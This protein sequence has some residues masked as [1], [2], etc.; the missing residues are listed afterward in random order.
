MHKN[1]FF[2][3]VIFFSGTFSGQL[4]SSDVQ[5]WK[6][7]DLTIREASLVSDEGLL[8]FNVG[9]KDKIA[10]KYI[11]HS[12]TKSHSLSIVHTSKEDEKIWEN[13]NR[14]SLFNNFFGK[15]QK[16]DKQ[17]KGLK[18]LNKLMGNSDGGVKI[19]K[20]PSI[21]SYVANA[22]KPNLKSDSSKINFEDKNLYELIF[23]S[24]KIK[25]I[26][27]DKI[28]SYLSIK[29]GI[30]LEKGKYIS[31]D[32]TLI[33]D[34]SKHKNFQ[35]RPTGL[36]RD[37]G[38]EL[39]QKQS[40]NAENQF[41][42][43]GKSDI[44]KMNV[45]NTSV[46]DDRNFVMWSDDNKDFTFRND[47][48][49]RILERNWEI[50]FVGTTIPKTD[51]KVRIEKKIINP[52]SLPQVYWMFLKTKDGETV[53][54]QGIENDSYIDFNKVNFQ[55]DKELLSQ[56]TFGVS[57]LKDIRSTS[58]NNTASSGITD[59]ELSLN[60]NDIVLYPNPVTSG[61]NF[62]IKFPEMENLSVSIYDGG[63]RLVKL[64][65][66]HHYSKSYSSSLTIQS[67]YL[68]TL[69]QN[70]KVIKTFKLIVN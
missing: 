61:Q 24:K 52:E 15:E 30:S 2:F 43:V 12:K 68:I 26:D 3:T 40:V 44:K 4:K 1:L 50:N 39:Y 38:N 18:E 8:N 21:F 35:H 57:P 41:L 6:K 14:N 70:G 54:L 67:T 45:E 32:G 59:E 55:S 29:Y 62:S 25:K 64:E 36:G 63:G 23:F 10:K 9:I 17:P 66:I 53:K 20:K 56:F 49:F 33:W 51:Y 34:P 48:N 27:L 16:E 65:K 19:K 7:S 69:V 60:L 13:E 31:S 46:F 42:T 5:I 58:D 28:H 37:D 47:G 22:E 11:K